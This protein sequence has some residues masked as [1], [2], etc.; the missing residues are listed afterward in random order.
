MHV[1][2]VEF[3][4]R[5]LACLVFA[6][7]AAPVAAEPIADFYKGRSISL[8]IAH[9][10]GTGYDVYGRTLARH[11]GR[12]IPGGPNIVVQNM[13]GASGITGA[14]LLANTAAKDG[15][16]IGMFAHTV[17]LD[18]L[19]GDGAARFDPSRFNWLGNLEESVG[20][21]AVMASA[22]V[23]SFSDLKSKEVIFGASATTGPPSQMAAAVRNLFGA[24]IK[25]VHG[26]RGAPGVKVAIENG[27]VAGIC[28]MP[29]S[30][31]ETQWSDL[32]TS[33]RLSPVIQLSGAKG[34][35][36]SI[37]WVYD[38]ATSEEDQRVFDLIFG[39]LRLGKPVAAPPGIPADRLAALRAAFEA[40]VK[41][42]QFLADAGRQKIE[43]SP[44]SAADVAA[45]VARIYSSPK[46][47]VERARAA[48][49]YN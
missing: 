36:P 39:I 24:R 30:T 9:E 42:E 40:T 21:C 3:L 29:M 6:S 34:A 20:V 25:L 47:A 13:L 18:P 35:I 33:G 1:R 7:L 2:V 44:S 49:R 19:I 46:A 14:N 8:V 38:L 11:I 23:A 43:I 16:V 41:D 31:L 26:Y 5:A 28:G 22:G 45:F 17:P 32:M 27:E 37:T 48:V 10:V 4:R 15:S 12:H